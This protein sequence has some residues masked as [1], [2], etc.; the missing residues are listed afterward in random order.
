MMS[1]HQLGV[2][3]L[4]DFEETREAKEKVLILDLVLFGLFAWIVGL[5]LGMLIW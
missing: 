5:D 4:F 2:W 1:N 3:L